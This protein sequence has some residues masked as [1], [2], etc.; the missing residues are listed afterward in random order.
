MLCTLDGC[1]R[2]KYNN[3]FCKNCGN[4]L[5]LVEANSL[6]RHT[7]YIYKCNKCNRIIKT[8]IY[9]PNEVIMDE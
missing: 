6:W 5:V 1:E 8:R 4:K 7:Q 9:R 3:G 2:N